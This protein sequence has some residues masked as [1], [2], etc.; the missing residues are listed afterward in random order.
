MSNNTCF[1]IPVLY[2]YHQNVK[3]SCLNTYTTGNDVNPHNHCCSGKTISITYYE[4]MFVALVI[5]HAKR[6]RRIVIYGLCGCT[7]VL[8]IIS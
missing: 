1:G 6:M 8:H 3:W 4:Y 5:Q 2:W 7:V